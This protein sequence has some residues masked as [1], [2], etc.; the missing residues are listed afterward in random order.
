MNQNLWGQHLWFVLHTISF[1]YPIKP[2]EKDKDNMKKFLEALQPILPC[3]YCRKNYER[4]LQEMPMKLNSR[5]DLVYWIIDMHNQVNGETGKRQYTYDEVIKIY[6]DKLA[7]NI[8]F[9]TEEEVY[10]QC[11]IHN[12]FSLK[13]FMIDYHNIII[14]ILV[15]IILYLFMLRKK[16]FI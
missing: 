11:S 9:T 8:T 5:K 7:K 2:T 1:N 4:H 15:L 10:E 16:R 3:V 14:A 13:C 6:E 12:G